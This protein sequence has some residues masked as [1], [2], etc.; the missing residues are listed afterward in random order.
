[1]ADR[2][3]ELEK[4]IAVVASRVQTLTNLIEE[5]ALLIDS[6]SIAVQELY[7]LDNVLTEDEEETL[8]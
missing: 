2:I 3:E 4:A 8:H 6:L 5:Q 1:M 7:G